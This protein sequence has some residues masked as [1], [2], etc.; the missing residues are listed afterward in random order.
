MPPYRSHA[1]VVKASASMKSTLALR[2]ENGA[3][4]VREV[5]AGVVRKCLGWLPSIVRQKR[6][7]FLSSTIGQGLLIISIGLEIKGFTNLDFK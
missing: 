1:E 7:G 6:F 4:L 5:W 3:G 2:K